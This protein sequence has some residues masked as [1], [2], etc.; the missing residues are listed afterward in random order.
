VLGLA[1]EAERWRPRMEQFA[2]GL[3]HYR[4]RRWHEAI[5]E[6]EDLLK[7]YP[8]DGP[9]RCYIRRCKQMLAEPPPNDW[10]GI[11]TFSKKEGE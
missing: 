4:A 5:D 7:E 8:G 1:K 11:T 3:R 9:A 2:A 6:L 10:D